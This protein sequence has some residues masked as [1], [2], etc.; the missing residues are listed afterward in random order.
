MKLLRIITDIIKPHPSRIKIQPCA[1]GI[2]WRVV[3]T[4]RRKKIRER[5]IDVCSVR[6]L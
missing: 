2:G 1:N 4:P 3:V 6:Y 5:R